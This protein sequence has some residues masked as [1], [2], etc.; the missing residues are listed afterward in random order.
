MLSGHLI[1]FD[2][3]HIRTH[4]LVVVGGEVCFMLNNK[5]TLSIDY[6]IIFRQSLKNA[7]LY[8]IIQIVLKLL[9]NIF[10]NIILLFSTDAMRGRYDNRS[11]VLGVN[12]AKRLR[13]SEESRYKNNISLR[14][15]TKLCTKPSVQQLYR[16][17][18]LYIFIK[19]IFLVNRT[20]PYN[21]YT[22][23]PL[24]DFIYP[25]KFVIH[26]IS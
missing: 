18:K 1:S 22:S 17:S 14:I 15:E 6:I 7:I 24:Y 13:T 3:I 16:Y 2:Y 10:E 11:T 23:L 12:D 26:R 9:Q 21:V 8:Y 25:G 4:T 19:S 5:S 20:I